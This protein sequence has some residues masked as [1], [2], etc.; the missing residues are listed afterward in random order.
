M[1]WSF[2]VDIDVLPLMQGWSFS[3]ME[4]SIPLIKLI[5]PALTVLET[6]IIACIFRK[7]QHYGGINISLW[8]V[9]NI[10]SNPPGA[11][12][13]PRS[14]VAA[15]IIR[16]G[17]LGLLRRVRPHVE[18]PGGGQKHAEVQLPQHL[19][20]RVH[21]RRRA[22]CVRGPCWLHQ[23]GPAVTDTAWRGRRS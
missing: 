6:N 16:C 11:R 7:L 9:W 20:G 1:S 15:R 10:A 5:N 22:A 21:G 4:V 14:V 19:H 18:G 8:P 3:C 12:V 2:L 13:L 17:Q 23:D